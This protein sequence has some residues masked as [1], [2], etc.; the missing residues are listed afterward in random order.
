LAD[1]LPA[2]LHLAKLSDFVARA[3]II[4][5]K[6]EKSAPFWRACFLSYPR[7]GL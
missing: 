1:W 4:C 6:K 7:W 3:R 5:G 2:A